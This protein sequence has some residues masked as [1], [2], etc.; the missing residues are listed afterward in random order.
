MA[1]LFGR[2]AVAVWSARRLFAVALAALVASVPSSLAAQEQ[3]RTD[4]SLS[5]PGS[6]RRSQLV[7]GLGAA[8]LPQ[9]EGSEDYQLLPFPV[10]RYEWS[11]HFVEL[12]GLNARADLLASPRLSAGPVLTV[13]QRRGDNADNATIARLREI[14]WAVELGGFA[15][16]RFGGETPR[17]GVAEIGVEAT[18]DVSG[19]HE[20][21]SASAVANYGVPLSRRVRVSADTRLTW[22]D[23]GYNSTYFGVDPDN[24][25]RSGLPVTRVGAGLKDVA[26]GGTLNLAL[27][28]QLSLLGRASYARLL[29]DAAD[30]PL[31]TRAGSADQ[32]SGALAL[33]YRF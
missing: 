31:I 11:G 12:Q 21:W 20:G 9:F 15:R 10:A 18:A 26:V 19:V 24:A 30:S 8:H 3:Q 25:A 16:L 33:L 4:S 1:V 32:V 29:G 7:V 17:S 28:R 5:A 27:S 14:D 22:A 2:I 13:R 23:G 6:D